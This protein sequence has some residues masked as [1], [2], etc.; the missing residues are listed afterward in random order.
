[1][2]VHSGIRERLWDSPENCESGPW[3]LCMR[4]G[5]VR[6]KI[7]GRYVR[8]ESINCALRGGDLE[9]Q[10]TQIDRPAAFVV[11]CEVLLLTLV[12]EKTNREKTRS[13]GDNTVDLKSRPGVIAE[14]CDILLF[15]CYWEM[16]GGANVH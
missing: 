9:F 10:G 5:V 6:L 1:M 8:G 11:G 2:S 16:Q 4:K 7:S 13:S 14:R 15:P 12:K 3:L